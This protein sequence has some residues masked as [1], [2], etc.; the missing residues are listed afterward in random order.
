M[1]KTEMKIDYQINIQG[2]VLSVYLNWK[3]NKGCQVNNKNSFCLINS[4]K[5]NSYSDVA[6]NITNEKA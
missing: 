1:I 3:S 4:I 6:Q 2:H 5:K